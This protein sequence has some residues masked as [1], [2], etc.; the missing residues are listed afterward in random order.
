MR[1]IKN[2]V[3]RCL[4]VLVLTLMLSN[5]ACDV[6]REVIDPTRYVAVCKDLDARERLRIRCDKLFTD[7]RGTVQLSHCRDEYADSIITLSCPILIVR[8]REIR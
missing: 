5:A 3:S 8:D 4:F 6:A 1:N 7:G 2:A